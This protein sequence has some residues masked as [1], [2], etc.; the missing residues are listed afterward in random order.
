MLMTGM[1]GVYHLPCAGITL[2]RFYGFDLRLL[3]LQKTPRETLKFCCE[4][5]E[6]FFCKRCNLSTLPFVSLKN[7][8]L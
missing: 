8:C 2:I 7:H 6:E 5:K 3:P 1:K 4:I